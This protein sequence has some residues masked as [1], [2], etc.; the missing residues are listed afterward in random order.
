MDIVR[1]RDPA[2]RASHRA[3]HR[4][5]HLRDRGLDACDEGA[6]TAEFAV[7]LPVVVAVAALLLGLTRATVVTMNCH[8]AAAVVVRAETLQSGG[9]TS[10]GNA[11]DA[12]TS[13]VGSDAS[14][15][16]HQRDGVVTASVRCP[17]MPDPLSI[18]PV[19]VTATASGVLP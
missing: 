10:G 1:R 17:V 8:R 16:V 12:V 19:S 5:L 18:L 13:M 11:S 4:A 6:A 15:T 7:L 3:L 14:V 9:D 2:R